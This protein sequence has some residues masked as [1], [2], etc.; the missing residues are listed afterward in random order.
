MD[1]QEARILEV[2]SNVE[3]LAETALRE[4]TGRHPSVADVQAR[5]LRILAADYVE[6]LDLLPRPEVHR[7]KPPPPY[8]PNASV[9]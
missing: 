6:V 7:G 9:H 1:E 2:V 5:A 8:D 3:V 4:E